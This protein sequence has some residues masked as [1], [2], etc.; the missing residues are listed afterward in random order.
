MSSSPLFSRA[1]L[2]GQIALVTG[3]GRGIGR[4]IVEA[5]AA[6]GAAVTFWYVHDGAAAAATLTAVRAAGGTVEAERVDVRD[7]AACAAAVER[8]GGRHGRI[9]VLVNNAGV[10]RDNLL[11]ALT[12]ADVHDVLD[13]NVSGVFN[14]TRPVVPYMIR[15][16]AG[17]IVNVS[18][19]AADRGGRGQ[20][21]YAASKGALDAF[22]R[23]L[24]V[25]LAPRRV[26]VNA[27]APGIVET[28]MSADVRER[29]G[30]ALLARIPLGRYGTPADVAAAVVFLASPHAAYVTGQVLRVDGGLSVG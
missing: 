1:G 24:A 6:E 27:V 11:G 12:D 13:T 29:A 26:R 14:V 15:Q 20:T 8:L 30:D 7:A 19:V 3:G 23:A 17:V 25:E 4:A 18:S 5:L 22:T 9:D 16:R 21:N 28:D 10:V 2:A